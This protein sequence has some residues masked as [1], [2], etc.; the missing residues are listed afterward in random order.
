MCW[1]L[2]L[3]LGALESFDGNTK[4]NHGIKLGDLGFEEMD[5]IWMEVDTEMVQ[6]DAV[7]TID[8]R[9]PFR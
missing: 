2:G 6:R 8:S 4:D 3:E 5:D 7:N 9:I 1:S